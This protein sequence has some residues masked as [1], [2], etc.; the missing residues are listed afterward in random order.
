MNYQT[1]K[2]FKRWYTVV[3]MIII[4]AFLVATYMNFGKPSAYLYGC[5]AVL[6]GLML[7]VTNFTVKQLL[8]KEK[9]NK[10]RNK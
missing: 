7:V 1:L 8:P 6:A 4:L 9:H 5:F 10:F 2:T 3:V